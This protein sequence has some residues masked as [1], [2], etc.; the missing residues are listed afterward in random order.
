VE[1]PSQLMKEQLGT[2][3]LAYQALARS[4][5]RPLGGRSHVHW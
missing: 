3:L 1:E 5:C 2:G 4:S